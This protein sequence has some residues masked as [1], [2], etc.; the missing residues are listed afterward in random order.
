ML[1]WPPI[2]ICHVTTHHL[3]QSEIK[4]GKLLV[5]AAD[6]RRGG[7]QCSSALDENELA[8]MSDLVMWH[9][10]LSTAQVL[11]EA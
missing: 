2:V 3:D 1:G 4:V 6:F 11:F 10:F 9:H 8:I 7:V 5:L